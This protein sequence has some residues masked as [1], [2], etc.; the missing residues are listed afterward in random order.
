M[1]LAD[2]H[3]VG[4]PPVKTQEVRAPVHERQKQNKNKKKTRPKIVDHRAGKHRQ[5]KAGA[6][7]SNTANSGR[8]RLAFKK[9]R[10]GGAALGDTSL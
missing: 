9:E 6:E 10:S 7:A 8:S 3:S 5:D 2:W 4:R 1:L